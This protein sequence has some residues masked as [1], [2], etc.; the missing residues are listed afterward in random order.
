MNSYSVC[1]P[2]YT[3]QLEI[4][5]TH[6]AHRKANVYSRHFYEYVTETISFLDNSFQVL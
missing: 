6:E 5:D 2:E 4:R 1:S 3:A